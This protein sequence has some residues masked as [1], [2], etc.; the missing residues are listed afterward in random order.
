M[1]RL[2]VFLNQ[3]KSYYNILL[4]GKKIPYDVR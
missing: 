2:E 1:Y 4:K 3:L